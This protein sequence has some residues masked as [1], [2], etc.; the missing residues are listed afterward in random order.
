M[1]VRFWGTRGSVPTPGP[2]TVRYGGN[3]A[4][5]EIRTRAQTTFIFDSGTGIRELGLHLTRQGG[6]VAAHL[7]LGHTHWDHISGFPFFAPGFVPGN[8]LVIYG[9][10][11]LAQPLQD[12]LAQQMHYTYFPV[13]LGNLRADI[14]FVE[15]DEGD[16]RIDDA[17]VRTHALN[18]TAVCMGYRV[19]ADGASV[20]YITD[21]EPYDLRIGGEANHESALRR[22]LRGGFIPGGDRR[23]IEFVRGVD[24]LIQDAQYTHEEYLERH[25]WGHGSTDYV[26]DVAVEAGVKRLALFHHEPTHS[27]ADL[28]RMVDYARARVREVGS[29]VEIFAAAEGQALDL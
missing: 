28:D 3:T 11:D 15:L 19:E 21:H 17:L 16:V 22:G 6:Q 24:L 14:E 12:V 23:L 20:A 26:A 10:H 13:P 29:Q 4:C 18:H 25:G 9:S 2:T 1:R 7:M 5:V 8:R 27:D